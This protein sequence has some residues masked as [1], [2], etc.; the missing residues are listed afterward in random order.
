MGSGEVVQPGESVGPDG[1]L[2]PGA[3]VALQIVD[4]IAELVIPARTSSP[5]WAV[6]QT[7]ELNHRA[8]TGVRG[9]RADGKDFINDYVG[10]VT[11]LLWLDVRGPRRPALWL[12]VRS[13]VRVRSVH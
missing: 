10:S 13:S 6:W 5:S 8:S 12:D 7:N 4:R 2:P 11:A 3:I 1:Q 9:C